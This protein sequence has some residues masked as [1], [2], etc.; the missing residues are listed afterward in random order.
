MI[1]TKILDKNDEKDFY[2]LNDTIEKNLTNKSWWLPI[3]NSEKEMFF[4]KTKVMLAGLYDDNKLIGTVSLYLN[5]ADF[6]SLSFHIPNNEKIKICKLS[7]G[8]INPDYRGHGYLFQISLYLLEKAK[9]LGYDY[10]LSIVHPDNIASVKTLTKL[11][12]EKIKSITVH[13]SFVRNLMG[14]KF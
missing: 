7:R 5:Q 1:T 8:M 14:K 3:E 11:G 9:L 2:D 12:F 13:D 4:D 6:L 10:V